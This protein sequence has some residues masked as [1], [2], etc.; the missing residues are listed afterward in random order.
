[1]RTTII[2]CIILFACDDPLAS[3]APTQETSSAS[4]PGDTEQAGTSALAPGAGGAGGSDVLEAGGAGGEPGGMEE[5]AGASSVDGAGGGAPA[6]DDPCW[7][8]PGL[9]C[10]CG[11]TSHAP[12]GGAGYNVV[13]RCSPPATPNPALEWCCDTWAG[14]CR[15]WQRQPGECQYWREEGSWIEG[16]SAV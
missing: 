12:P 6:E 11:L 13:D 15:C 5:S 7:D 9:L 3:P 4:L 10:Y 16:C 1:M 8:M 2:A 14:I